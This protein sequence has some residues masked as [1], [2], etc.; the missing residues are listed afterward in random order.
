MN[1]RVGIAIGVF[2]VI[3]G[4]A[5]SLW[6]YKFSE[7][8]VMKKPIDRKLAMVYDAMSPQA[9]GVFINA[10]E[11]IVDNLEEFFSSDTSR[12]L[13]ADEYISVDWADRSGLY[14]ANLNVD[15]VDGAYNILRKPFEWTPWVDERKFSDKDDALEIVKQQIESGKDRLGFFSLLKIKDEVLTWIVVQFYVDQDSLR[16]EAE[17]A[18]ER[19]FDLDNNRP[20]E[21]IVRK[22]RIHL[23]EQNYKE[24]GKLVTFV[25]LRKFDLPTY[26]IGID[27]VVDI[28]VQ[29]G[30]GL[31]PRYIVSGLF[32][33]DRY[34][35]RPM[36]LMNAVQMQL[37]FKR[38]EGYRGVLTLTTRDYLI[39]D[40]ELR[41]LVKVEKPIAWSFVGRHVQNTF[42]QAATPN[43]KLENV[44]GA[45]DYSKFYRMV[46]MSGFDVCI[47]HTAVSAW[48]NA[49]LRQLPKVAE[50]T[51]QIEAMARAFSDVTK[52]QISA[53]KLAG[54]KAAK[55]TQEERDVLVAADE[56]FVAAIATTT[57]DAIRGGGLITDPDTTQV[58]L[59]GDDEDDDIGLAESEDAAFVSAVTSAFIS[60][61][62]GIVGRIDLNHGKC[63]EDLDQ[64]DISNYTTHCS[65]FRKAVKELQEMEITDSDIKIDIN[66]HIK[67]YFYEQQS[68]RQGQ[69][70]E[71]VIMIGNK[72]SGWFVPEP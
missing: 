67:R 29:A 8:V 64:D 72:G 32:F 21:E 18:L 70:G 62:Q 69:D 3:L 42:D 68:I 59:E 71:I 9:Q 20:E 66:A 31:D 1:K 17:D 37:T 63:R 5:L 7:K 47:K 13:V 61:Y 28:G 46:S 15:V 51:D 16:S 55:A 19:Y 52:V 56:R 34:L 49:V 60:K 57:S 38:Q 23:S 39:Q 6:H 53:S 2:I 65:E 35:P 45:E 27:G 54:L 40:P 14:E 50:K 30:F 10:H 58:T 25:G 48:V 43:C 22:L 36:N 11:S 44:S 33:A 41:E 24:A 12:G 26:P 4:S